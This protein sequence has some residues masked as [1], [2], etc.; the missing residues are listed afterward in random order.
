[1]HSNCRLLPEDV[2]CKLTQRNNTRRANTCDPALKLLNEE[3]TSDI[4]NHKQNAQHKHSLED[5]TWAIQ[6]STTT[7]TKHIHNIQQQNSNYTQT[8]CELFHQTIHKHCQTCNT[9]NKQDTLT[10]TTSRVQEAIKRS[11]NNNSQGPD[12][13]NIRHLKHMGPLGLAFLTSMFKTALNKNIIPH[14]WK[15]ANIVPIPKPN[16]DRQGHLIQAHIPP[17]SN[18]KDTGEEPSSLHNSKHTKHAHATR[19]QNTTLYSDGIHTLNNTVAKGFNQMAP[20]ARTNNVA[21]DISKAFDT[22]NIHA[23]IRKLLQ[24]NI[25]GTIFNFIANYIKGCKAYTTYRNHASKQRQFPNKVASFHPHYLTFRT[26]TYHHPV[27]RFR[28][29]PMQMTSRSHPHTQ[30]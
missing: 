28:S 9:Q 27:H 13:L 5:H 2:V 29:W 10:L 23:L 22:I 20:P 26:Q 12:K 6:Q 4:Q 18:C 25:P 24:T 3:I 15:L 14:T 30:V 21:L 11:K 16:K 1:M 8:H 19:V 7:H 17:L